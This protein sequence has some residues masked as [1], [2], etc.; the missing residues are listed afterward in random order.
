MFIYETNENEANAKVKSIRS[1]RSSNSKW[2]I[3]K[4]KTLFQLNKTDYSA[5]SSYSSPK[6]ARRAEPEEEFAN[7]IVKLPKMNPEDKGPKIEYK[8]G[9]TADDIE[10][11]RKESTNRIKAKKIKEKEHERMVAL[12]NNRY[13]TNQYS[14]DSDNAP[15]FETQL[16]NAFNLKFKRSDALGVRN[17]YIDENELRRA[18]RPNMDKLYSLTHI[19][20]EIKHHKMTIISESS[21]NKTLEVDYSKAFQP[22]EFMDISNNSDKSKNQRAKSR[23]M[24]K[25]ANKTKIL[26]KDRYSL[27]I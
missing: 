10:K 7:S 13:G 18:E 5:D 1:R 3:L 21:T 11:L 20:H 25:S 26:N 2:S 22:D 14:Y 15:D 12:R 24:D 8:D 23:Q 19:K 6:K 9:I 4:K 27:L 17:L 16:P